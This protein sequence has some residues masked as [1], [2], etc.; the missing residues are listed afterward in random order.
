MQR[1]IWGMTMKRY[2]PTASTK[3][4]LSKSGIGNWIVYR[5]DRGMEEPSKVNRGKRIKVETVLSS[6]LYRQSLK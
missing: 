2:R 4:I 6:K 3:P 5:K 1:K